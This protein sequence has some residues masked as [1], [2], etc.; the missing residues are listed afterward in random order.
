MWE[1]ISEDNNKNKWGV[2]LNSLYN[3]LFRMSYMH[4]F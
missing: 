4:V 2:M 3:I 1:N